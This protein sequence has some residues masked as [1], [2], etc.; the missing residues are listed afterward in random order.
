MRIK[1]TNRDKSDNERFAPADNLYDAIR[2][3]VERFGP[4]E[5][6]PLPRDRSMPVTNIYLVTFIPRTGPKPLQVLGAYASEADAR[7]A[8][9]RA[10]A[11]PSFGGQTEFFRV[12]QYKIGE[13]DWP[14]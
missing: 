2:L 11:H 10:Q 9:E 8:I 4:F 6:K 12:D 3:D 7:A 1:T 14:D 13:D 5:F